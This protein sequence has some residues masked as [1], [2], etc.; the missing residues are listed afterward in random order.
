MVVYGG[1]NQNVLHYIAS[2]GNT[3]QVNALASTPHWEKLKNFQDGGGRTALKMVSEL[4]NRAKA[5]QDHE[6][7]A[8][9]FGNFAEEIGVFTPWSEGNDSDLDFAEYVKELEEIQ[10]NLTVPNRGEKSPLPPS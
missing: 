8:E 9:E 7:F 5:L 1:R 2:Y 4:L 10:Q 3:E 6:Y